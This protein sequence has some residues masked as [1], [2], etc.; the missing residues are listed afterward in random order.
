MT[1]PVRQS[2]FELLRLV[3]MMMVLISHANYGKEGWPTQALINELPF[4][5]LW[6]VLWNCFYSYAVLRCYAF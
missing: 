5:Y 6:R 2:N 4:L 1:K 3:C